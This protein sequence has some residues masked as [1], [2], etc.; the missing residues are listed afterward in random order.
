MIASTPLFKV[1]KRKDPRIAYHREPDNLRTGVVPAIERNF[2]FGVVK[3]HRVGERGIL[4]MTN[5]SSPPLDPRILD[6]H[7]DS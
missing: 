5:Q 6:F 4:E 1:R 3:D 7:C 2:W